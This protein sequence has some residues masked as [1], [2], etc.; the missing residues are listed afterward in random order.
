MDGAGEVGVPT[1]LSTFC[2]CIVFVPV[3]LLQGTAK[4][5]FS[6][7]SLSVCIAL[8]ASLGLSFTMV[9]VLFKY[10][11]RGAGASHGSYA[12]APRWSSPFV[13]V[14]QGFEHRFQAFR[15]SYRLYIQWALSRPDTDS[16]IFPRADDGFAAAFSSPGARFFSPGRCRPDA[17]PRAGARGHTHRAN[18]GGFRPGGSGYPQARRA[19][20]DRYC[21]RQ[22]RPALQRHEHRVERLGDGGAHGRRNPHFTQG[23]AYSNS[24]AGG[25]AAP[26]AAQALSGAAVLLSAG[27]YRRS[28]SEFRPAGADRHPCVRAEQR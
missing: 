8:L 17:A 14:Q 1:L 24:Q 23:T 2:I 13:A 18:S 9:P 28:G 26:R 7:L 3:F 19:S 22:H 27:R 5:L 21:A 6:P 20:T 10:L 15:Q 11:M 12:G 25:R 16:G 4:Y